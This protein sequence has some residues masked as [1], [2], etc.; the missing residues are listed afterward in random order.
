MTM[1]ALF[2][3]GI[4]LLSSSSST[5]AQSF[6]FSI[7]VDND[8]VAIM[9]DDDAAVVV[10][11]GL[12]SGDA[13]NISIHGEWVENEPSGVSA[14]FSPSTGAPP[15]T[16][17]LTFTSSPTAE[18]GS[19]HYQVVADGGGLT[20]KYNI[21]LN[22]LTSL[23]VTVSTDNDN[24]LKGQTIHISGNVLYE[25]GENVRSG[26]VTLNLIQNGWERS[27]T[28]PIQNGAYEHEYIIS[29]GDPSGTWTIEAESED[30]HGNSGVARENISV[31]LQPGVV[32][33]TVEFFAPPI[34]GV[35]N[36]GDSFYISVTVLR[37]DVNVENA[38]VNCILPSMENIA[39][40]E[41]SPGVYSIVY[42][43]PWSA[44][45]ENWVLS[46]E[47]TKVVGE[48]LRAGG[49]YTSVSVRPANL[50][51][52][53]LEP[54]DLKFTPGE[55][56]EIRVRVLYPDNS[57]VVNAEVILS[58]LGENLSLVKID[59]GIYGTTYVVEE[60]DIGSWFLQVFATD[61]YRN[62]GLSHKVTHVIASPQGVPTT[63]FLILATIVLCILPLFLY[64]RRRLFLARLNDIRGEMKEIRKLREE[65]A[66]KY[67]KD[68]S[69][70]RETYDRLMR[71]HAERYS[72]LQKEERKLKKKG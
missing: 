47:A 58:G 17:V 35:Y 63:F 72:E 40:M 37:D 20:R 56:M 44:Q 49:A 28:T 70:S 61:A 54:A 1:F 26:N 21:Q 6:D 10:S 45:T 36:R 38:K 5:S 29:F 7:E 25:N 65:A 23:T 53:F 19:F 3:I 71:K 66:L 41:S 18:T 31:E 2:L 24:Y 46:V 57:H 39:L 9:C 64:V 69:I 60:N 50:K 68:G 43:I 59:N 33:Y 42:T 14:S 48:S 4:F 13:E 16:S 12:V 11:I 15:F 30:G 51:I 27:I 32:W 22:I 62:T 55:K 8:N 67:F 52:E 34:G